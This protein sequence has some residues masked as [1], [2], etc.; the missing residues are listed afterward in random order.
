MLTHGPLNCVVERDMRRCQR[1]QVGYRQ[2]LSDLNYR[3]IRISLQIYYQF[4][5][6]YKDG[7][8]FETIPLCALTGAYELGNP[9]SLRDLQRTSRIRNR[10]PLPHQHQMETN[11]TID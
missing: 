1:T 11:R 10:S 9:Q 4:T 3:H 6:R 8:G 2:H 7:L 5:S